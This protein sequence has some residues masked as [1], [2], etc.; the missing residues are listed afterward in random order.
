MN[1]ILKVGALLILGL[2]IG[3]TA[4]QI[5]REYAYPQKATVVS[6]QLE[7]YLDEELSANGTEIDWG[8]VQA[9]DIWYSNLTVKNVGNVE[10]TVYLMVEGLPAGWHETWENTTASVN[11]TVLASTQRVAGNLTLTVSPTASDG[12]YTWDSYIKAVP[13]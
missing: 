5:I 6:I 12:V 2:L 3:I 7:V 10:C 9:G 4:T 1:K 8:E 13:T 11:G